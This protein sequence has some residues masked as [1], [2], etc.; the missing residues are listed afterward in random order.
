MDSY[1]IWT[2]PASR[3]TVSTT[4]SVMFP[5]DSDLARVL[6]VH[7]PLTYETLAS[8]DFDPNAEY[9]YAMDYLS[10]HRELFSLSAKLDR[11]IERVFGQSDSPGLAVGVVK[12]QE[13]VYAKGFG[14]MNLETGGEVTPRTLFH[15]ASITKPFVATSIVQLLEKEKLSLDDPI[16]KHLPYFKMADRR[17][18]L[19][20]PRQF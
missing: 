3:G 12:D 6:P 10:E 7:N 2:T 19:L 16:V 15:M 11:E 8:Y 9:L 14:V 4:Y 13:I 18:P 20:P 5:E 17:Y 1:G